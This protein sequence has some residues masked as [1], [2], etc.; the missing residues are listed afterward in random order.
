M[1]HLLIICLVLHPQNIDE[2]LQQTLKEKNYHDKMIKMQYGDH[3]V[4][5]F[6]TND[7]DCTVTGSFY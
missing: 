2:S 7:S 3:G 1:Y 6:L 4:S 5:L